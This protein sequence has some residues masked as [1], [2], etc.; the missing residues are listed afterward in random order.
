M[1]DMP[2][3]KIRPVLGTFDV[4]NC[5]HRNW[6]WRLIGHTAGIYRDPLT[7][8]L[9]C[10]E[11]TQM[12]YAGSSGVRLVPLK[13]WIFEYPGDVMVK[14]CIYRDIP[15]ALNQIDCEASAQVHIKTHR[16]KPYPD[17]KTRAG[18]W[19]VANAAIDLPFDNPWQNKERDDI[20]FCTH[21]YTHQLRFCGIADGFNAAEQE[22]DDTR[23]GGRFWQYL[24]DAVEYTEEVRIVV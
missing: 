8:M 6:F 15:S 19:F 4:L 7:G 16:G 12:K 1:R 24:D 13:Q 17:L 21:L 10:Y 3:D 18:K 5:E 2:Y 9:Y 14:R 11:S 22:P 23:D 20:F